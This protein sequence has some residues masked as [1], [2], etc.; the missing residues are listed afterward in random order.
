MPD[1]PRSDPEPMQRPRALST[2]ALMLVM[3]ALSALQTI[4][5]FPRVPPLQLAPQLLH[6]DSGATRR[7]LVAATVICCITTLACAYGLWRMRNWTP[8]AYLAATGSIL[9][10][11][12]V[13][14]LIIRSSVPLAL[15]AGCALL[16]LAGLYWGWRIVRRAFT[17]PV[18]AL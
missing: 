2:L 11:L 4:V 15:I 5:R 7:M 13:F 1:Y 16:L 8:L 18:D 17:V 12:S 14:L 9:V 10:Y 6:L 3:L